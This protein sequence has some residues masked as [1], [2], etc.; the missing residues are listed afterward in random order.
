M[1]LC[2][3]ILGRD[4]LTPDCMMT[5]NISSVIIKVLIVG[6]DGE[7]KSSYECAPP[8]PATSLGPQKDCVTQTL[9]KKQRF[10]FSLILYRFVLH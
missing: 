1:S 7:E 3:D 5:S 9:K 4:C 8:T 10:C 2:Q 6:S